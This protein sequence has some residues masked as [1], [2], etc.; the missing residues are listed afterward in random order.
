MLW[1]ASLMV[2]TAPDT[3]GRWQGRKLTTAAGLLLILA[4]LGAWVRLQ[5]GIPSLRFVFCGGLLALGFLW[6]FLAILLPKGSLLSFMRLLTG[7]ALIFVGM[8]AAGELGFRLVGFDFNSVTQQGGDPRAAYPLCFRMPEKPL[9]DI[10]FHR[11]GPVSWTGKPLQTLLQLKNSTD[12]AYEDEASFT[13]SYDADGFRN[14][15][16][17]KDWQVVVVGDSFVE[18][19]S[20]PFDQ[21]FTT[22]ASRLSGLNIRNLG[23]CNTGN[24]SHLEYFKQFGKSPSCK[25]AI[26]AFYDGNDIVDTSRETE[27]LATYR[28]TQMR[29]SREAVLQPSL[30]KAA[31][32]VFRSVVLP[33]R[34]RRYQDA[35][36]LTG[37]Q[38]TPLTMRGSPMPLDPETMS[39]AQKEMLAQVIRDWAESVRQQGIQPWLLYIPANNRTYQGLARFDSNAD[40]H[41][42]DWKPGS[43]PA[44]VRSLCET[45]D[46]HFIDAC[47][48]LR[49]AAEKGVLVYNRI[50]D[51]HLNAEGSRLIGELLAKHL[52]DAMAG[53]VEKPRP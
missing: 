13:A 29:P 47:P 10:Y 6:T 16:G 52:A 9:G 8:L 30:I 40:P 23:V 42:R 18:S 4:G 36:L 33:P 38:E 48:P 50:L 46:V 27:E 17:M 14:P 41:A 44:Y 1:S 31:V 34:P 26:L 51:T 53:A 49:Q 35:W 37:G 24:L 12:H 39:P 7:N 5:P 19:G 2:E 3:R 21:I 25:H 28:K 22:Q 15:E 43:L 45:A 20:L 11:A 32:Q